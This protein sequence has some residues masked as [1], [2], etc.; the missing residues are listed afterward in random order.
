[1]SFHHSALDVSRQLWSAPATPEKKNTDQTPNGSPSLTRSRK[2]KTKHK[3]KSVSLKLW[4]GEQEICLH[5]M[6]SLESFRKDL[7][8]SNM[9]HIWTSSQE[10]LIML[11]TFIVY[12]YNHTA[13]H[14]IDSVASGFITITDFT[15]TR[16]RRPPSRVSQSHLL[17]TNN[18]FCPGF[19]SRRVAVRF[20]TLFTE[21]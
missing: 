17:H 6:L 13:W 2:K 21:R 8:V 3:W 19:E 10:D 5:L 16:A 1:M 4:D 7:N 9:A 14:F 20:L 18:C 15:E 11:S 12:H